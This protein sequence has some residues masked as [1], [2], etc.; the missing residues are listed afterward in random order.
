MSEDSQRQSSESRV[1]SELA[2][3]SVA[4]FTSSLKDWITRLGNVWVEGQI[5]EI[6]PKKDVFF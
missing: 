1:S 2:P 4:N 3:W 6:S 5:S